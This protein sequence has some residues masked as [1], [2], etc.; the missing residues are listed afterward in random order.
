MI[1]LRQATRCFFFSSPSLPHS[2]CHCGWC[3]YVPPLLAAPHHRPLT[4]N[5][6]GNH[7]YSPSMTSN[8]PS[9]YPVLLPC[10]WFWCCCCELLLIA[11]CCCPAGHQPPAAHRHLPPATTTTNN[12]S[13][14]LKQPTF[15]LDKSWKSSLDLNDFLVFGFVLVMVIVCV[16]KMNASMQYLSCLETF[17]IL[18][19]SLIMIKWSCKKRVLMQACLCYYCKLW[20]K[21]WVYNVR[22]SCPIQLWWF[23]CSLGWVWIRIFMIIHDFKWVFDLNMFNWIKLHE[24]WRLDVLVIKYGC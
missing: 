23:R 20:N 6:M 3:C 12:P 8:Q 14:S 24:L 4:N 22:W 16:V 10:F 7:Q 5:T 1:K 18:D 19:L 2:C 17:E 21:S 9:P 13:P 11:I 15:M